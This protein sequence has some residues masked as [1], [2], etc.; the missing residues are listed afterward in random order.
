VYCS[1][2]LQ[3]LDQQEG[4]KVKFDKWHESTKK[5]GERMSP[6][7]SYEQLGSFFS[8]CVAELDR[9]LFIVIDALDE[10]DRQSR[11]KIVTLFDALSKETP[12]LKVLFTCRPLEWVG[13][14][15]GGVSQIRWKPNRERDAV[16]VKHTVENCLEGLDAA[17]QSLVIEKLSDLAD[18]SAIWV[19]LMVN[20]IQIRKIRSL[21]RMKVFLADM[22]APAELSKLYA[23]LFAQM[24]ADDSDNELVAGFALEVLAVAQRPLSILEF[25]WAVAL[26]DSMGEVR[27]VEELQDY[28]DAQR[29][30][31]LV[32]PFISQLDFK[33]IRRRQVRLVHH[34][35]KTLILRETPLNWAML[36]KNNSM[37]QKEKQRVTL[38]QGKLE[39]SLLRLCVKYLLLDDFDQRDLFSYDQQ[40]ALEF[41]HLTTFGLPDE[42]NSSENGTAPAEQK[43]HPMSFD[44]SERGFGEFFI[45]ASCFWVD[46]FKAVALPQDLP[47]SSDLVKLCTAKSQR[48]KNWIAQRCRPDCTMTPI[49]ELDADIKDPL[50]AVSTYGTEA[51][52]EKF[53]EECHVD[54]AEFLSDSVWEAVRHILRADEP[55]RLCP[56]VRDARIGPK[57]LNEDFFILVMREAATSRRDPSE[58]TWVFD[59]VSEIFDDLV[60]E[61]GG[62]ELL[63]LAAGYGCLPIVERLF[64][65]ASRNPDM[66]HELLRDRQRGS[67]RQCHH[68]SIGEA[69]RYDR[70]DVLHYMLQQD[71]IDAHLRHRD[72]EGHNVIHIA[73]MKHNP[74]IV[75]L[76]VSHFS[77]GVNQSN[78][79]GETPLRI[80]LFESSEPQTRVECAKILLA[81]GGADV[82]AGARGESSSWDEPLRMAARHGGVDLCRVLVEIGGADPRSVLKIESDGSASLMDGVCAPWISDRPVLEALCSWGGLGRC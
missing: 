77:E 52:V 49:F 63:C 41:S 11:V 68:Q 31:S 46:H 75:A 58:W 56:I 12:R 71:G 79:I 7:R 6:I 37:S 42:D 39:S 38:R 35:L 60:N 17:T 2:T 22:S 80:L 29:V 16:I 57:I 44:P 82:R 72:A 53:L 73:A 32:Q 30:L 10:C 33:D 20:L 36:P 24:T 18:G 23:R 3:L 9:P 5:S 66:K 55:S 74:D 50:D 14:T 48:L 1:L 81:E 76:L 43:S 59:L 40:I 45:Y 54:D 65:Q 34:S 27:L 15:L 47:S 25:G 19:K 78:N 61:K 28:V 4:L 13:N 62:N 51:A 26:S 21:G 67:G 8:T 70:V 69:A 64:G